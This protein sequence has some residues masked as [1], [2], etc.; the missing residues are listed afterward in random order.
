[1][2]MESMEKLQVLSQA[3]EWDAGEPGCLERTGRKKTD[4]IVLTRSVMRGGKTAILLKSLLTSYCENNCLYCPFRSGRD[5]PR[6][7]FAPDEFADLAVNLTRAGLIQGVF[8]SSGVAGSGSITQDRLISTAEILRKKK[9]YRGYLHLKIMPGS[10]FDQV[11]RAMQLADRVSV[12]L[13]AP[14]GNRLRKLAPE[15]NFQD[16]LMRPLKWTDFIRRNFS[17]QS[18]WKNRWPTS[19]TQFVVGG[20]GETDRELL[21]TTQLLHR[22]HSL[23]RAYF[24]AFQPHHDTPLEDHPASTYRREQ[25]LYQADYLIRDYG[26]SGEELIYDP[27]GHLPVD[28]DPKL[29]WAQENLSD[30]RIEINSAE[31]ENLLRIPGIGPAGADRIIRVRR[32]GAIRDLGTLRKWGI[33]TG[34]AEKFILLDGRCPTFQPALF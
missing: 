11:F 17:P 14:N 26:F 31:R 12:N 33:H 19:S 10:D 5:F 25:R 29:A 32:N 16:A 13:E 22:E 3:S 9:M 6:A 8:L 28:R 30:Q 21:E 23:E 20:A 34:R 7:S 27:E 15:K 4:G 18:A 1:M 2:V 24:S